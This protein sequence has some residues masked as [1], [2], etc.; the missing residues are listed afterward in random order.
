MHAQDVG[1]NG[2][3]A[4]GYIAPFLGASIIALTPP[5]HRAHCRGNQKENLIMKLKY[6]LILALALAT[7]VFT[8]TGEAASSAD[9]KAAITKL[10]QAW[11]AAVVKKDS[12]KMLSIGTA[13]CWFVDP[14]GQIVS[15][16]SLA[17]DVKSGTYAVQSMHIDDLKVRVYGDSAVVFGLETEK[18]RYN[19]KD[20]S[21]QYRFLDT[22]IKRNGQW[23]CAASGNTRVTPTKH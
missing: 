1:V 12:A 18:S 8:R 6:L 2:S 19:G 11:P 17:A 9:D 4:S 22:W 3:V 16:K 14:Y 20:I 21:G 13:D 7:P 10:E 15:L 23:L 5:A